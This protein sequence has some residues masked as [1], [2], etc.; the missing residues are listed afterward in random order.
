MVTRTL[1]PAFS[2]AP[3]WNQKG[4]AEYSLIDDANGLF[5]PSGIW[6]TVPL[7]ASWVQP[8]L[9]VAERRKSADIYFC[10]GHLWLF[11]KH[12]RQTLAWTEDVSAEFLPVTI[13]EIGIYFTASTRCSGLSAV[14]DSSAK[15]NIWKY[16]DRAGRF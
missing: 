7:T 8:I 11:S 2:L 4:E 1:A 16:L 5:E 10:P 14:C 6:A 12:A 3:V 13:A 15:P 9:G